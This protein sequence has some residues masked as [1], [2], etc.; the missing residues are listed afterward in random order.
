MC[1]PPRELWGTWVPV[2]DT[3]LDRN[4]LLL[5]VMI[6]TPQVKDERV[7]EMVLTMKKMNYSMPHVL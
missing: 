7:E 3:R 6:L 4:F 2:S 5:I 1:T